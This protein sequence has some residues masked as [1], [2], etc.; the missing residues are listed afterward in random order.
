MK[1]GCMASKVRVEIESE[2]GTSHKPARVL[3]YEGEKLVATVIATVEP[4]PGA[5]GEQYPCVTLKKK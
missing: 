2:I 4:K 5:D 3:V 1:G